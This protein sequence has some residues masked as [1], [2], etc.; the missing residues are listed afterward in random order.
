MHHNILALRM[1]VTAD[2]SRPLNYVVSY[3]QGLPIFV[4]LILVNCR[5]IPGY[6]I[7]NWDATSWYFTLCYSLLPIAQ[8]LI[9][10]RELTFRLTTH[11]HFNFSRKDPIFFSSVLQLPIYDRE[12]DFLDIRVAM[13]FIK[14]IAMPIIL[15]VLTFSLYFRRKCA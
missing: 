5:F 11:D 15:P 6:F 7:F 12:K 8:I 14:M 2:F 3:L 4:L 13:L 1:Y 10:K 9:A